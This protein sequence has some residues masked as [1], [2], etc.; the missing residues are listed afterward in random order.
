MK[1]LIALALSLCIFGGTA[2]AT[3]EYIGDISL[4]ASA[5]TVVDS[6]TC[7]EN[8]TWV[9]D[10]EG[11]LTI[12]GTG[13]MTDYS[14]G[15]ETPFSMNKEIKNAVIENG[16]TNIGERAFSFCYNLE[17]VTIPSSVTS[18][19]SEAFYFCPSLTSITI[20]DSVTSIGD[21]A[22]EFCS[23]LR[24]ITLPASVIIGE[25]VFLDC[26]QL[27]TISVDENNKAYKSVNGILF[28]KNMTE[29]ICFPAGK[30][31]TS[32]AIPGSVK[33]IGYMAF[34]KCKNLESVSIP[35]TVTSIGDGAF[36]GCENLRSISIPESITRLKGTFSRC[37]SLESVTVP[38]SVS[39]VD[40]WTFAYCENLRSVIIMNPNCSIGNSNTTVFNGYD[41]NNKIYFNGIIYGYEGSTAQAYAEKYGYTFRSLGE[42]PISNVLGDVD[43]NE[44]VDGRDA[45]LVLTHYALISTQQAGIIEELY[46]SNAD[47]DQNGIVDGRDASGILTYYAEQSVNKS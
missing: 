6:G 2:P 41:E 13:D 32:Y 35:S 42:S 33:S 26:D 36:S 17:S 5:A 11:T 31:D 22:F 46:L 14:Y 39:T 19:K 27:E 4:A 34:F 38:A 9:L 37:K 20:P 10:D 18:I 23:S 25:C 30:I 29:I 15:E 16:V 7:G 44:I 8:I 47:W 1:K 28:D 40:D 45:S 24:S 21:Y 12:S 3:V 43:G